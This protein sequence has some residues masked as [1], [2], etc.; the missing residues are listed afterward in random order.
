MAA[1]GTP[2]GGAAA[3]GTRARG[4]AAPG[5]PSR[6]DPNQITQQ[7]AQS[8]ISK[9]AEKT[10]IIK[11]KDRRLNSAALTLER[12]AKRLRSGTEEGK[13]KISRE[14]AAAELRLAK[15]FAEHQKEI[16]REQENKCKL[17]NEKLDKQLG[18]LE[19]ELQKLKNLENEGNK[20]PGTVIATKYNPKDQS[21]S[22]AATASGS[23][24]KDKTRKTKGTPEI[25]KPNGTDQDHDHTDSDVGETVL[26]TVGS[27]S[28]VEWE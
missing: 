17:E 14:K 4:T 24:S 28:G 26:N 1:P 10:N 25:P 2:S 12:V 16:N 6:G 3:L 9:L 20:K 18:M 5:T 11:E 21:G 8:A 22:D 27:L 7:K 19:N 15:V 13:E 23:Q